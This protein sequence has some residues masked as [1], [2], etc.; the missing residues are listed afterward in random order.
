MWLIYLVVILV[1]IIKVSHHIENLPNLFIFCAFLHDRWERG[2]ECLYGAEVTDPS[3]RVFWPCLTGWWRKWSPSSREGSHQDFRW[4]FHGWT[5]RPTPVH[6]INV[7]F[8]MIF[9]GQELARSLHGTVLP[10]TPSEPWLGISS[11]YK[12]PDLIP[13]AS[14]MQSE[15]WSKATWFVL[16]SSLVSRK[17]W[18]NI[19][20]MWKLMTRLLNF[21]NCNY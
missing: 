19:E 6:Q 21:I 10:P 18:H 2:G 7:I 20:P 12:I 15:E 11:G 3:A 1:L 8:W 9:A 17:M 4:P 13:F 5:F 14:E 16:Q